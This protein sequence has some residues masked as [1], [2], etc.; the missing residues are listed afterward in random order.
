MNLLWDVGRRVSFVTTRAKLDKSML[1]VLHRAK[2]SFRRK[3]GQNETA[4][5]DKGFEM[6]YLRRENAEGDLHP[7]RLT[8]DVENLFP[9][10]YER[11]AVLT[12]TPL[13][14]HL[15]IS[16]TGRMA[17]IRTIDPTVFARFKRWMADNAKYRPDAK[18]RRD[19]R[20][21]EILEA[22]L[23]E[24]LLLTQVAATH[25]KPEPAYGAELVFKQELSD[26]GRSV[27]P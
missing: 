11:P 2:P 19:V 21:A 25:R 20:Q 16:A 6:D 27:T 15:V 9:V 14:E 8:N 18:R 1:L 23:E 13:F 4:I 22:L 17:L 10:Q 24:G 3:D 7:F 26:S 5:D 12:S